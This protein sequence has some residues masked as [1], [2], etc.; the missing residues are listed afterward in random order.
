LTQESNRPLLR[1]LRRLIPAV[2][3]TIMFACAIVF[4]LRFGFNMVAR[5]DTSFRRWKVRAR[6]VLQ[7]HSIPILLI[8][9]GEDSLIPIEHARQIATEAKL[10]DVPLETYFVSEAGHCGAYGYDP[11]IYNRV[12]Q[13]FL[14]RHLGEDFP[15]QHRN[16]S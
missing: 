13:S 5:P 8:H 10:Q 1:H 2:A 16:I 14:M 7:Q 12:I 11:S 9:G 3:W 4:R 15:E 6:T